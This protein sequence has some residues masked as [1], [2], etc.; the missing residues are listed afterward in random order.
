MVPETSDP[1]TGCL[2]IQI[3]VGDGIDF[4]ELVAF[5]ESG[6]GRG[7][8]KISDVEPGRYELR[9]VDSAE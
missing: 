6:G 4:L 8:G 1:E 3:D 2:L 7:V 5:H 9:R